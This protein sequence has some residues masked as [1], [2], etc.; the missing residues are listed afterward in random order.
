MLTALTFA[1]ALVVGL[2]I[3]PIVRGVAHRLGLLDQ[4][5]GRKVHQVPVPRLGGVGM[6]IAFGVAI[7][8]ATII[9]PDLG[10][11]AVLRPNRALAILAGVSLLLV[12]GIIDDTRGMR[13]MVKLIFQVAA[14]TL[15]WALGLSIDALFGPW[16]VVSLGWLSLPVTVIW[17]VAVINAVNLI[18]GLDGL[19]SAV[20]LTVLAAFGL[21]AA[22]DGVDP[23]LPIIAATGGAAFGFLAYNLHPASIIMGDTGSMFL[24]FVVAAIGISLTQDG[25]SPVE[26]WVPMIALGVPILDT[27]W[28][29]VRRTARGEPFFVADRGHIHHQLLRQGLS[30]RDAML[31]LTAISA[32]LATLAVVVAQLTER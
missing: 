4:P 22:A 26:P 11:T 30:Q 14:A 1:A 27:L 3:T 15:A 10:A 8:L 24:G 13:A 21:L 2:V 5:G 16:G 18:D 7:G 6:A 9:S 32:A 29:I 17:V 20:V 19:A 25:L 31:V 12:V 28:A 23:T